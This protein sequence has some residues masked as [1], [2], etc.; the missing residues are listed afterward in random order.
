M[1]FVQ[2]ICVAEDVVDVNRNSSTN[3]VFEYFVEEMLEDC[4]CV[5]KSIADNQ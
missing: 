5:A 3:D 1:K 4:W 2:C